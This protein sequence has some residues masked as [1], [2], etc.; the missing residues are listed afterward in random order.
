[1]EIESQIRA[2]IRDAVNHRTRK[3]FQWG[4]LSGYLQLEAIAGELHLISGT[5]VGTTYLRRLSLQV[6]RAVEQNRRLA[7][8]LKEAHGW[9]RRIADCL[10][11]PPDRHPGPTP[12][13]S[14]QQVTRE[15]EALMQ[16]FRP[17]FTR[18]PAQSA[19]F[20]KW[21]RLWKTLGPDLVHCYD[22]P[23][24]PPDN[25]R[26]EGF[27]GRV[28]NH[29]RRISGR[30]STRELRNFGQY[31]VL[32]VAES[33]NELLE[34]LRQVP[35]EKYREHRER[36][37]EAEKPRRF[38]HRLH[39]HPAN[40]IRLLVERHSVRLAELSSHP[41]LSAIEQIHTC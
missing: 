22:I 20:S 27:F 2:A 36:L 26:L 15:M 11:Y 17:D 10:R 23:C 16:E 38:M 35:L 28:R 9:L 8:D 29:Q 7:D 34:Q 33:E 1:M 18:Q 5:G 19:L 4:G 39:R 37:A 21:R 31:Q 32:F 3:P 12:P 6:D 40:T 30:Q 13:L 25:L 24:L 41:T 14:G